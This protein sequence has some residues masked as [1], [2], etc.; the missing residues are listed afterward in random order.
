MLSTNPSAIKARADRK[1]FV[2]LGLCPRCGKNRLFG[3][4]KNCREC[5]IKQQGYNERYKAEHS[6]EVR[7][8]TNDY[9]RS[10]YQQRKEAGVCVRCGK[11][12]PVFND[13]RCGI[14]REKMQLRR[15]ERR[16]KNG[17]LTRKERLEQGLCYFCG[18]ETV[19]GM[20]VCEKHRQTCLE[21]GNKCDRSLQRKTL[22]ELF[23]RKG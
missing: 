12:K 8:R 4:E 19:P 14:C 3:D 10:V 23:A 20:K 22:N 7:K 18:A 2:S 11:R 6:E 17:T 9:H 16:V 15:Q 5:S 21:N 1:F 13:L